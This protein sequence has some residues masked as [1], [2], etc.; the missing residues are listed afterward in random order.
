MP[1]QP[2]LYNKLVIIEN[3]VLILFYHKT[4][5]S[6]QSQIVP[7]TNLK[8]AI[9]LKV[10][11]RIQTTKREMIL[12][13]QLGS[14]DSWESAWSWELPKESEHG[15]DAACSIPDKKRKRNKKFK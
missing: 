14:E 12:P 4:P 1:I 15:L 5:N 13:L 8:L 9:I 7:F 2:Y 11:Q 6:E 3:R 10:I